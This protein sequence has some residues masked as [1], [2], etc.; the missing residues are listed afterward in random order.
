[1]KMLAIDVHVRRFSVISSLPFAEVV[2]RL[3]A[4]IG[5]PDIKAFHRALSA[6]RTFSDLEAVVQAVTGSS[7]LMEFIRFDAGEVLRRRRGGETP[8]ILRLIV[9]NPLIM[10][11]MVKSVPDAA[12]YAP[13]T[14]LVT[15][16]TDGIHLSYDSMASLI[17]PYGDQSALKV[18]RDLD[19]KILALLKT[20]ACPEAD[21]QW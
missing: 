8:R 7:G 4:T 5:H 11:E 10:R 9:G 20:T 3:T 18:A 14:I 16:R 17:A 15:E 19:E 12:S 21:H 1:M 2:Q 13:V 6:A